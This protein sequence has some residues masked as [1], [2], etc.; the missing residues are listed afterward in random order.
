MSDEYQEVFLVTYDIALQDLAYFAGL[1]D[2]EGYVIARVSQRQ[3]A[4][5]L[6]V[7]N[8]NRAVLEWIKQRFGGR[9]YERSNKNKK[10]SRIWQWQL[11]GKKTLPLLKALEPL[12][13]IKGNEVRVAIQMLEYSKPAGGN[14]E[15]PSHYF[16]FLEN[17]VVEIRKLRR[18]YKVSPN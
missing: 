3:T 17:R 1:F 7:T 16:N 10:H 9:I 8:T 15:K 13:K 6:S 5:G 14:V 18:A 11:T 4:V 12:L 2:G